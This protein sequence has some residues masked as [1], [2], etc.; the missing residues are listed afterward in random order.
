VHHRTNLGCSLRYRIA[1]DRR[2]GSM[3]SSTFFAVTPFSAATGVRADSSC[4]LVSAA[5]S[6]CMLSHSRS[7]ALA[8]RRCMAFPFP[9]MIGLIHVPTRAAGPN[10]CAIPHRSLG[11]RAA[12]ALCSPTTESAHDISIS[13]RARSW[14]QRVPAPIRGAPGK[15]AAG[16]PGQGSRRSPA[17]DRRHRRD[18][19]LKPKHRDHAPAPAPPTKTPE[20]LRDRVRAALLRRHA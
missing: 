5:S 15:M 20:Q 18:C 9:S 8:I 17:A 11:F 16:V 2:S 4:H 7:D 10:A 1:L 6:C 14:H 19:V 13:D 12:R 3:C